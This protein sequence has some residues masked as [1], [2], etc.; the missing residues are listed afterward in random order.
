MG[1]KPQVVK[2]NAPYPDVVVDPT[3]VAG[4]L[5]SQSPSY[6]LGVDPRLATVL[7]GS[8]PQDGDPL[9]IFPGGGLDP[10][11]NPS[12]VPVARRQLEDQ[13]KQLK[14]QLDTLSRKLGLPIA[15]GESEPIEPVDEPDL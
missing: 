9:G 15:S 5:V 8:T 14:A 3:V 13:V 10:R 12:L 4:V 7:K 1:E 6:E 2:V 11:I